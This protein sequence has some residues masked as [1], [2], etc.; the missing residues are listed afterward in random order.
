MRMIR[1]ALT[2]FAVIAMVLGGLRARADAALL[3]E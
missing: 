1:I 3:M 2:T